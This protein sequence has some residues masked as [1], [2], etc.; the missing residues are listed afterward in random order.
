M[1]KALVFIVATAVVLSLGTAAN[2]A[3]IYGVTGP[4]GVT[5][6][7]GEVFKI[8]TSTSNPT[9]TLLGMYPTSNSY[10]DIAVTPSGRLYV[11]GNV[12][13]SGWA[14]GIGEL[15]PENGSLEWS[16]MLS[17]TGTNFNAL[18]AESDTSLLAVQG[19]TGG[20]ADLYRLNLDNNGYYIGKTL[21]GTIDAQSNSGGDITKTP[22]GSYIAATNNGTDIY[23]FSASSP[24]T[25]TKACDI[26]GIDWVGA[27]AYD[28]AT[29]KLYCGKFQG[30]TLYTLNLSTGV[31]TAV[32]T[33]GYTL[34]KGIFGLA[35]VPEPCTIAILGLGS[36]ILVRR[37]RKC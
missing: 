12:G 25:A 18:T 27:L 17:A 24:L 4:S 3:T 20:S 19:G 22:S 14:T 7:G 11:V 21:L 31:T 16:N 37:K 15:D 23:E 32:T 6:G 28:Y 5:S 35:S 30:S 10:G 33:T 1:K 13:G 9:I 26:V 2:A 36:F 29:G 8:D 34:T